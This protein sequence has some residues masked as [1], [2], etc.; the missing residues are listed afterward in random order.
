MVNF[1]LIRNIDSYKVKKFIKFLKRGD[2]SYA[3][4]KLKTYVRRYNSKIK[5]DKLEVLSLNHC[6]SEKILVIP[7]SDKPLVSIIIPVYNQW[8]YTYNCIKQIIKNTNDVQYEVILADDASSDDTC[9]AS[10]YIEN[11]IIKRNE[12]N[13][14]FIRNCNLAANVAK[15]KYIAFLNNDTNVQK[16][17][18]SSL[19]KC[20]EQ[21]PAAGLVGSK[22]VYPNGLLQEAGGIVWNDGSACNYGNGDKRNKSSYNYVKEVDYISGASILIKKEIWDTVNGFDERFVPAY[23]EDTDIA[24]SIREAGYKILYQP[25]SVVVHFE[26]MSNGKKTHSGVKKYQL[27]NRDKFRDKWDEKL[28][29]NHFS[30]YSCFFLARDKSNKKKTVV[31]IDQYVP[32]IDRDAGSRC[33]GQYIKLMV[34]M[35]MHVIFIGDDYYPH[36]PYTHQFQQYG[37]EILSGPEWNRKKVLRWIKKNGKYIECFLLAR[38]QITIKYIDDLKKDTNAKIVYFD[39]D[40]HFLRFYREYELHKD[41]L[42]KKESDYWRKLETDIFIKADAIF[43]AGVY[44]EEVLKKQFP[45]KDISSIP[46]YVYDSVKDFVNIKGKGNRKDILFVGGFNHRPNVDAV[47]WFLKD[48]YPLFRAQNTEAVFHIVGHN[49]PQELLDIKGEMVVFEGFVDDDRLDELYNTACVAVVPLRYGAGVKGKVIEA[50]AKGVPIVT[51]SIGVEGIEEAEQ[52]LLIRDDS[53]S[54]AEAI[55][56]LIAEKELW[57]RQQEV[58]FEVIKKYFSIQRMQEILERVI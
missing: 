51:T 4:D 26:G 40:L 49:P 2:F 44:E 36:Q 17:W 12:T 27:V 30:P 42:A 53:K 6:T 21:N 29:S 20:F 25:D 5:D 55:L 41:P 58:Q 48:I 22:L 35:G 7:T 10:D 32:M 47:K 19:L 16:K 43:T 3:I 33:M 8:G 45:E 31:V 14:G 56:S 23:Y 15:G 28:K 52:L 38:P 57:N 1:S 13:V 24:F 11:L 9:L 39:E 46:L 37:I 50:M 54:F 34:D 18:L